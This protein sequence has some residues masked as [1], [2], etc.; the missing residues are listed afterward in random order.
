MSVPLGG[1]WK[2][3]PGGGGN[4]TVYIWRGGNNR[5]AAAEESDGEEAI[6]KEEGIPLET[7]TSRE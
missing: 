3:F 4:R 1:Q 2:G 7:T 5:A 6:G